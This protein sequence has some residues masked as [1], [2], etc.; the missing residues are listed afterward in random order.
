MSEQI[1]ILIEN[2][3]KYRFLFDSS[4]EHYKNVLKKAEAWN[5]IAQELNMT[6]KYHFI[7]I[8]LIINKK[9]KLHLCFFFT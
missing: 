3:R 2:V 8:N 7:V 6:S 5:E 1:E 9:L 4:H